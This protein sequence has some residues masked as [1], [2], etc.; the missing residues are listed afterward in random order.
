MRSY[1]FVLA[2]AVACFCFPANAFPADP[3]ADFYA[4]PLS[5]AAEVMVD[6]AKSAPE[7]NSTQTNE[8]V[9]KYRGSAKAKVNRAAESNEENPLTS[10]S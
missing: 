3:N 1:F 7:D 4:G 5:V 2:G 6:K 9:S 8:T 10:P